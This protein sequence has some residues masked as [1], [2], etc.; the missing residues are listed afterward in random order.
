ML[1][2]RWAG[3][4][5][6]EAIG[7]DLSSAESL[8]LPLVEADW[9]AAMAAMFPDGGPTPTSPLGAAMLWWWALQA[10]QHFRVTLEQLSVNASDWGDFCHAA[11]LLSDKSITQ[12]PIESE[13]R[14]GEVSYVKFISMDGA[15]VAQAFADAPIEDVWFLT[16]VKVGDEWKVWGLSHNHI[17]PASRVFQ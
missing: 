11:G 12:I 14:P 7:D 5:S 9:E 10:T 3:E 8:P 2:L 4:G 17:P 6:P 1:G 16:M 15:E 13:E